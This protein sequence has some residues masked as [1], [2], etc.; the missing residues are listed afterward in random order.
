MIKI[1]SIVTE[2]APLELQC[3]DGVM[4]QFRQPRL[5]ALHRIAPAACHPPCVA[6]PD[7]TAPV[8]S[9]DIP[10]TYQNVTSGRQVYLTCRQG[11]PFP[12]AYIVDAAYTQ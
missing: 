5:T 2:L 6:V 4:C 9:W 3:R 8:S 1:H 11:L 7:E 12:L 10:S